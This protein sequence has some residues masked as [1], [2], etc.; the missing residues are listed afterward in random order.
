MINQF[1]SI[2]SQFLSNFPDQ[3]H[4]LVS[5]ILAGLLVFAI[6]QTI[7]RNFIWIILLV[8]LLPASLPI[9]TNIWESV[10]EVIK[11]LLTKK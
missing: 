9:L 5:L 11:F 8:I 1:S 7:R 3:F 6:F 10:L 2:Y 4:W